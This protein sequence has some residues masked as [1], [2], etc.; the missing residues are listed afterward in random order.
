MRKSPILSLLLL[1]GCFIPFNPHVL[2]SQDVFQA[3]FKDDTE[4]IQRLFD[5]SALKNN[6]YISLDKREY[7]TTNSLFLNNA[8]KLII[9]GN[10]SLFTIFS[11]NSFVIL[12]NSE[13]ITFTNFRIQYKLKPSFF[14]NV[15]SKDF[16]DKSLIVKSQDFFEGKLQGL[17]RIRMTYLRPSYPDLYLKKNQAKITC[18]DSD[19]LQIKD[20]PENGFHVGDTI[21]L[22]P[23]ISGWPAFRF[24]NCSSV[25]LS[26]VQ[27]NQSPGMGMLFDTCSDIFIKDIQVKPQNRSSL[28]S[29]TDALHFSRCRGKIEIYSSLFELMGDDAINV[30]GTYGRL[31]GV[32]DTNTFQYVTGRRD[33]DW[34]APAAKAGDFV[35]IHH[36]SNP[37]GKPLVQGVVLSSQSGSDDKSLQ[38]TLDSP[39]REDLPKD[40]VVWNQSTSPSLVVTKCKFLNN[41]A[42]GILI[43]SSNARIEDNWFQ[44]M[45]GPAI[46][47][48]CDVGQWWE[49]GPSTNIVIRNNYISDCNDGPGSAEGAI[50][51]NADAPGLKPIAGVHRNIEISENRIRDVGG[52]GIFVSSAANVRIFQNRLSTATP[53]FILTKDSTDVVILDNTTKD[54][55]TSNHPRNPSP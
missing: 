54:S 37:F 48:T 47:A 39:V 23:I 9:N 13:N 40:S 28:S 24:S 52:M 33:V 3:D 44:G 16:F 2:I 30:H 46:K 29:N 49:S 18:L 27:I 45:T 36:P 50:T 15:L 41:R 53:P 1:A 43:Q 19:H 32:I 22:R 35:S 8:Q 25:F 6:N 20:L 10:G 55:T 17:L 12:K 21:A 34:P 7:K 4:I 5:K 14:V 11:N 42:R 51:I 26:L 38:I 31:N